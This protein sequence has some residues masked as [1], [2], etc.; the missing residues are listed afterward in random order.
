MIRRYTTLTTFWQIF[1]HKN[2]WRS[3]LL[4]EIFEQK[5]A[6]NLYI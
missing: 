2:L 5:D 1:Q 4:S 6:D 3:C